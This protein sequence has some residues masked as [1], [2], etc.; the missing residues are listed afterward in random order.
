MESI[1]TVN[2]LAKYLKINPQVV[3]RM[4]KKGEIPG[5]KVGNRW[6]FRREDVDRWIEKRMEMYEVKGEGKVYRG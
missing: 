4:A 2:D 3:T 5:F 6:R 1:F